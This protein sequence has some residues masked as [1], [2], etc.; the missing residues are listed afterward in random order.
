MFASRPVA[1]FTTNIPF[2]Y[3]FGL[4]VVVNGMA[5]ITRRSCRPLHVVRRI[6]SRPPV[7]S[8]AGDLIRKPFVSANVPLHRQRE[9]VLSDLREIT[10]LPNASVHER[11]LVHGIRGNGVGGQ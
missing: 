1:A 10:L 2:G 4:G 3:L 8:F 11:D 7:T 9:I 5:A 6:E